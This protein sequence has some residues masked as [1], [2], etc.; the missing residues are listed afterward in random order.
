MENF[1]NELEEV[2]YCNS[3]FDAVK[4]ADAVVVLTEWNIYRNIDLKRIK[5]LMHGNIILDTRNVLDVERVRE[6]GF[7][8]EGVGR[9]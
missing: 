6:Y 2:L 5:K 3:E 7:V 8:Y 4:G 1:T 9:K